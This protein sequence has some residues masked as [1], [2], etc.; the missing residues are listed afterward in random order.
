MSDRLAK[1]AA[2]CTLGCKVN[3]YETDAMKELFAARGYE[4]VEFNSAADV[5]IVNTCTVTNMADR[6]SRQMLH[7]ARKRNPQAIV[8]AVGCYAQAAGEALLL[9]GQ[10]DLV[11]GNNQK[12]KIVDIVED[13]VAKNVP[14]SEACLIDIGSTNDYENL[15]IST[16]SEHTRAYIKIQ[17]GCNQFCSYCII[18]YARGR[19]RSRQP[20]DIIEE[21]KRLALNGYHE[22]VLTGIHISSYGLDFEGENYN[23][24]PENSTHLLELIMGIAAVPEILRIRLGSLEPRIITDDFAKQLAQIPKV[25]AHFHLSLQSACDET[26]QRMNRHYTAAEYQSR[27]DILRKY[28]TNPALTTDVIVGFPGETEQEFKMTKQ[29]LAQIG[30]AQMHIFKYSKRSGTRA[31]TMENQVS[32]QI[33]SVR[34]DELLDLEAKMEADYRKLWKNSPMEVLLEE[35]IEINGEAYMTGH[36]KEYVRLAVPKENLA[37]N[38][39]ISVLSEEIMVGEFLICKRID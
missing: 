19:V 18:P 16:V 15:T 12:N 34:S 37:S 1:R 35:E 24:R 7:R 38:S 22:V 36:S 28:F 2:F 11:V 31:E 9:D 30:F 39:L 33:K 8:T 32:E 20:Q 17:D 23:Y 3:Q 5:Y 10:I 25:C 26:L 14:L 13:Y 6:K 4:I 29:F 27:C 21:V